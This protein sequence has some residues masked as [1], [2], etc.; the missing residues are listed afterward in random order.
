MLPGPQFDHGESVRS[1]QPGDLGYQHT[2]GRKAVR[3]AI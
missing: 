2:V 1:Q 3:P